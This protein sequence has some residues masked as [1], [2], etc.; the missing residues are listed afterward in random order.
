[1]SHSD[2]GGEDPRPDCDRGDHDG[3]CPQLYQPYSPTSL[4]L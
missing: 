4:V 1:M 3:D 2:V